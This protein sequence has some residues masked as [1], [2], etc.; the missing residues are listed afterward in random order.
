MTLACGTKPC[1]ACS[2]AGR[3][4]GEHCR[5]VASLRAAL[6]DAT[7]RSSTLACVANWSASGLS[8]ALPR[9][10]PQEYTYVG[11]E[12]ELFLR[13]C[14]WS[15]PPGSSTTAQRAAAYERLAAE[16]RAAVNC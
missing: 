9:E 11:N 10:P 3:H 12:N 6:R 15:P 1:P 14:M 8:F 5:E 7:G 2:R 16:L 4:S 13:R